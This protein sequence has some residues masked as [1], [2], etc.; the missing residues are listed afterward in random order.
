MSSVN[1]SLIVHLLLL[2]SYTTHTF[3]SSFCPGALSRRQ[4][5]IIV[6]NKKGY[7]YDFAGRRILV[8]ILSFSLIL[9]Y[10]FIFIFPNFY[11]H[12]FVVGYNLL[13]HTFHFILPFRFFF[14]FLQTRPEINKY[15]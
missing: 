3:D 1:I 12:Q 5:N 6:S 7:R 2:L 13:F 15:K 14:C 4:H 9:F 8:H 11:V 10:S